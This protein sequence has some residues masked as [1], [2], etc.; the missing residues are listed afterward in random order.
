MR[1]HHSFNLRAD[2][3]SHRQTKSLSIVRQRSFYIVHP[4]GDEWF[5][6]ISTVPPTRMNDKKLEISTYTQHDASSLAGC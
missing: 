5:H 3:S 6:F 1:Q 2:D 4:D